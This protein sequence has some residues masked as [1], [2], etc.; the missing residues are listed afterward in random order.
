M[1]HCYRIKNLLSEYIDDYLDANDREMVEKHL[2]TCDKCKEIYKEL[3]ILED[4]LSTIKPVEAT[5]SDIEES[6]DE[7]Y[8]AISSSPEGSDKIINFPNAYR[9]KKSFKFA[10][11]V[12]SVVLA[13][14]VYLYT[15][16]NRQD[17]VVT[18][19]AKQEQNAQTVEKPPVVAKHTPTATQ[20]KKMEMAFWVNYKINDPTFAHAG[21]NSNVKFQKVIQG[22]GNVEFRHSE[23]GSAQTDI[24]DSLNYLNDLSNDIQSKIKDNQGNILQVQLSAQKPYIEAEIPVNNFEAFST[25]MDKI[26]DTQKIIPHNIN[27]GALSSIDQDNDQFIQVRITIDVPE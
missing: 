10:V 21:D 23:E 22:I 5:E 20:K 18:K 24:Y 2:A 15:Q 12:A 13:V 4:L 27:D 26:G 16:I 8:R 19:I 3:M 14:S 9:R 1:T 7:I 6:L 25:F 11:A 17:T